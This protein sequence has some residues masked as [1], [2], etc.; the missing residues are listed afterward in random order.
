[1]LRLMALSETRASVA[2][3]GS[4]TRV[5]GGRRESARGE[6]EPRRPREHPLRGRVV[7]IGAAILLGVTGASAQSPSSNDTAAAQAIF[8]QGRRLMGQGDYI[9]A[10]AKF[11]ESQRLDPASGT[12]LNLGT[13]YEHL[14]KVATAWS[15]FL[16][17]AALAKAS[18]QL[19]R[20]RFARTQATILS[21]RLSTIVID[22]ASDVPGLEIRRNGE[23]VGKVQWG[24]PIPIDPG[25]H[26]I[27]ASA[28][29][30]NR[31]ETTVIVGDTKQGSIIHVPPLA[32]PDAVSGGRD[33]SDGS[34]PMSASIIED[35][36]AV[37]STGSAQRTAAYVAGGIGVVGLAMGTYFGLQSISKRDEANQRC[38][39]S[40][41]RDLE[42]V[43]LRD[44]ARRNGDWST[45][46][47]IVGAVGIAGGAVLWMSAPKSETAK[48]GIGVT[49]G[50]VT[51]E[52]AW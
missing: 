33:G 4:A 39:A 34:R 44:D 52:G 29:Y 15:K 41:C 1:M 45:A 16:E 42:G 8:D 6:D 40:S 43:E 22:V 20:E 28:P 2:I 37:P 23:V 3:P 11:E 24:N 50:R 51:L 10:C 14:G 32:A 36:G 7:A 46:T 38:S 5:P 25:E 21:S 35:R 13:C 26:R 19:D 47:F 48:L 12:A 31:W 27:V 49:A 9:A 18:H 30:R 17:A